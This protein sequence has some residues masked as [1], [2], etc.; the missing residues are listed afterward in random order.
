M[1]QEEEKQ[2]RFKQKE[3]RKINDI[4]SIKCERDYF[5]LEAI[6]LSRMT[7]NLKKKIETL[8]KSKHNYKKN[9]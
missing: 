8:E 9:S 4:R 2:R 5:R 7:N 1:R 3:Q 6:R